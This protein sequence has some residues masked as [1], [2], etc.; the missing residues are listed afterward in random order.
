MTKVVVTNGKKSYS[1]IVD[2]YLLE[3]YC[4]IVGNGANI[5]MLDISYN[6]WSRPIKDN[7]S[8]LRKYNTTGSDS[9]FIFGWFESF[10]QSN[11]AP[12][13]LYDRDEIIIIVS[14]E[15]KEEKL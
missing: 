10:C 4:E 6:Y 11:D 3:Y 2:D 1:E 13:W 9:H 12:L 5:D 14:K 7:V 15:S 8:D